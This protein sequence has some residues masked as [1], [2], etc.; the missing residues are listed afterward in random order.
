M[1]SSD[2]EKIFVR[3]FLHQGQKFERRGVA[4]G[5][6]LQKKDTEM[7]V[8]RRCHTLEEV[9][10]YIATMIKRHNMKDFGSILKGHDFNDDDTITR[11]NFFQTI[12]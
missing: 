9:Y 11:G 12:M 3:D 8:N 10:E 5:K 1:S 2:D 6:D 4:K 7:K